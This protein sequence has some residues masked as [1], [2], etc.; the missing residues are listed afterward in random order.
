MS[1]L[2]AQHPSQAVVGVDL[3]WSMGDGL[4]EPVLGLRQLRLFPVALAQQVLELGIC[5]LTMGVL[6]S[7]RVKKLE[8]PPGVAVPLQFQG[9][10]GTLAFELGIAGIEP[11]GLFVA[12]VDL[13]AATTLRGPLVDDPGV[14]HPGGTVLAIDCQVLAQRL[15]G[16]TNARWSCPWG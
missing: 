3:P 11:E 10:V 1:Q 14:P 9:Q 2:D 12:Q 13:R 4:A 5:R 8:V 6:R 16:L 15:G 7:P